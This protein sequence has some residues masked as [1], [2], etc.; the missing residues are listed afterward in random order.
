[1]DLVKETFSEWQKDKVSRLA[2]ALA[3]YAVLSIPPLLVLITALVG[4]F[5]SEAAARQEIVRQ[6]G[7][8]MGSESAGDVVEMLSAA[9]Q[10]AGLSLAA[11]TSAVVLLF[12]ASGVFVQLQEAM[13]T[14]WNV[15]P[16]PELGIMNTIQKRIISF[17]MVLGLGVLLLLMLVISTAVA[18]LGSEIEE[19]LPGSLPVVQV[20]NGIAAFVLLIGVFA[21]LFRTIPDVQVEWR[22]VGLGAVVTAVLFLLGVLAIG[23]YLRNTDLNSS[24]GA[25]GS[26]IVLMVGLYYSAQVF[27]LGAEFTQVYANRYGSNIVPEEG[28]VRIRRVTGQEAIR[29]PR[30]PQQ[31]SR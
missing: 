15:M 9:S 5:A 7:R 30:T 1:M 18:F 23:I 25:A 13:N 24:Y 20:L 17:V 10:P 8:V 28:A 22:D 6:L 4:Q 27:F 31:E 14:V 21:L 11:L 12:G 2:A 3:F 16:D 29:Q 26:L 19:A